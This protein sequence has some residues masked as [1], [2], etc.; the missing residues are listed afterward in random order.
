[1]V[2]LKKTIRRLRDIAIATLASTI[3][4]FAITAPLQG[5]FEYLNEGCGIS[6]SREWHV[7]PCE[8]FANAEIFAKSHYGQ[9]IS[10]AGM[11]ARELGTY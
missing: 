2:A 11:L 8:K 7:V 9:S 6:D 1:M 3:S 4:C 10:I 5:R